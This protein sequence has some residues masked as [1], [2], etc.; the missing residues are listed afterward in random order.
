MVDVGETEAD[1]IAHLKDQEPQVRWSAVRAMIDARD[2]SPAAITA[3]LS[4]LSDPDVEVGWEAEKALA[5]LGPAS[6]Q[7]LLNVKWTYEDGVGARAARALSTIPHKSPETIGTLLGR[8]ADPNPWIRSLAALAV[9][10]VGAEA[11]RVVPSLVRGLTDDD[12]SVRMSCR[13]SLRDMI[14][15]A[16]AP[17][18][19]ALASPRALLRVGAVDALALVARD[20]PH[21][22]EAVSRMLDDPDPSVRE[23]AT[24]GLGAKAIPAQKLAS[25]LDDRAEDVRQAAL[26]VLQDMGAEAE[27][28]FP[29][30]LQ[31]LSDPSREVR[32]GAIAVIGSIG[33][34]TAPAVPRLIELVAE[35]DDE[36]QAH[37]AWALGGIGPPA[38]SAVPALLARLNDRDDEVRASCARALGE[39]GSEAA[40]PD[41]VDCIEEADDECAM[42]AAISLGK[43][44]RTHAEAL[45]P[46]LGLLRSPLPAIRLLG[47]CAVLDARSAGSTLIDDVDARLRDRDE[48]VSICAAAVL[49]SFGKDGVSRLGKALGEDDHRV[50]LAAAQG[51]TMAYGQ[52]WDFGVW[53]LP[54]FCR[55]LEDE[56]PAV[57][58]WAIECLVRMGPKAEGAAG[59]LKRLE[60]HPDEY[61]RNKAR[62]A[63]DRIQ[64]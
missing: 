61:A 64:R 40:I 19:E 1:W 58:C 51:L 34:N 16:R 62:R 50:R 12:P 23:A 7:A 5:A 48:R 27:P 10:G 3:L 20:D 36:E 39:I 47:L 17:L 26:R 43:I 35:G 14:A 28:A 54:G 8:L 15:E 29:R 30:L 52:D 44:A 32:M 24:Y 57:V 60:S 4:A 21:I 45:E 18:V 31:L 53:L 37:A 2:G 33:R 25:L 6:E 46:I 9:K 42:N 49:A 13:N 41:L 38:S 56:D 63:L 22:R 55:A 59:A 11:K